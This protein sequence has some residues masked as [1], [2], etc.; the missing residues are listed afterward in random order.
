MSEA[1]PERTPARRGNPF[2]TRLGPL[3][4][5]AWVAI[6][7]T[8]IIVWSVWKGRQA[9]QATATTADTSTPAD[10]VPQFVNQTY[11]TVMP[12]SVPAPS[13]PVPVIG[14]VTPPRPV[15]R[16]PQTVGYSW[17][18]TGQKWSANQLAVKLGVPLSDLGPGNAQAVK[19]LKNPNAPMPKG[20]HFTYAKGKVVPGV[21]AD[22]G[23]K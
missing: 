19:A 23:G 17:T 13:S 18:D 2:T 21:G 6:L 16:P 20:A 9:N 10:Q 3:P 1:A 7:G 11:T 5:W 14:P 15:P 22:A 8:L 4:M 12:P